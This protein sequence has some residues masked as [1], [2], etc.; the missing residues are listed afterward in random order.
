MNRFTQ[1][2]IRA[3]D[4]RSLGVLAK[5]NG[6]LKEKYHEGLSLDGRSPLFE[7]LDLFP[8]LD[9]PRRRLSLTPGRRQS[10]WHVTPGTGSRSAKNPKLQN[11]AAIGGPRNSACAILGL[12][13][14]CAGASA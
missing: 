10:G 8:D 3:S 6:H 12:P 4:G 9:R 2:D 5:F 14:I 11:E 7:L 1:V 13:S